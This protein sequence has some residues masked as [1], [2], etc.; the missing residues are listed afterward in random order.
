METIGRIGK[1]AGGYAVVT[2]TASLKYPLSPEFRIAPGIAFSSF[3]I[4]GVP[5]L[6]D[7]NQF[8]FDQAVLEFR[9]HPVARETHPVGVTFVATPYY[10]TVD[11]F[12]G[13]QADSYG[14]QFIAAIDRTMIAGRLY[15][16]VNL[17][18]TF[19]RT[20]SWSTGL[21][22]DASLLVPSVAATA[23]VLPWLYV[24]GEVR[25]LLG[26]SGL[27]MQALTD[28]AIYAGPTFYMTL[29]KGVSLSGAWEPQSWGQAG[30]FASGL[31]VVQFDRQQFKLRLAV[32]L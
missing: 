12:D 11:P 30:N 15:G 23:H 3:N 26:F 9:W 28:Q 6:A 20:R 17:A 21:T 18:Y 16:A 4:S 8:T 2:T 7:T 22:T 19:N 25:Y 29:G 31:D 32:D 14:A 5:D 27:A 13:S 24:G 1:Q 10:G